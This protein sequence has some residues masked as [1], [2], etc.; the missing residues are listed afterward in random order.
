MFRAAHRSSSG[1]LNC[2]CSLWFIYSCGDRPLPRLIFS[3]STLAT[4]GCKYSL[5]L[6]MMIGVPLETCWAFNKLGINSITKLHLVGIS[7]ESS[8]MHRSM[9]IK[10]HYFDSFCWCLL[11]LSIESQVWTRRIKWINLLFYM[12]WRTVWDKLVTEVG[13]C[14]LVLCTHTYEDRALYT[15]KSFIRGTKLSRW[16]MLR[17]HQ[18]LGDLCCVFWRKYVLYIQGTERWRQCVF[19]DHW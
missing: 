13:A 15:R 12:Y 19:P 3:H 7:T 16:W 14:C 11:F 5:E 4:I 1:A 6:L 10:M 9:N 17:L 2:I 18:V 8:T